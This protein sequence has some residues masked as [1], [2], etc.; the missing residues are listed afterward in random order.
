MLDF[1]DKKTS[2]T[3]DPVITR[4]AKTEPLFPIIVDKVVF[5]RNGFVIVR[6]NF[7]N[8]L[9]SLFPEYRFSVNPYNNKTIKKYSVKG[10]LGYRPEEGETL[11]AGKLSLEK[12]KDM[13]FSDTLNA[14]ILSSEVIVQVS[15][16]GEVLVD[17]E[18]LKIENIAKYITKNIKVK[19]LG[20]VTALK[21]LNAFA[22]QYE[23]ESEAMKAWYELAINSPNEFVKNHLYLQ[24]KY[25]LRS[26]LTAVD[27]ESLAKCISAKTDSLELDLIF[28]EY[29]VPM[30]A[31]KKIFKKYGNAAYEKIRRNPYILAN[32][33][34]IGFKMADDIG[35][36]F[37]VPEYAR[38]RLIASMDAFYRLETQRRG[39]TSL[40]CHDFLKDWLENLKFGEED[41]LLLASIMMRFFS[42]GNYF[43][44][45]PYLDEKNN[46]VLDENGK[47]VY[48]FTSDTD[49]S[50]DSKIIEQMRRI[51]K[52]V[53]PFS[54]Q[55]IQQLK[56]YIERVERLPDGK[57][58]HF[59][60]SQI[61]A[62]YKVL[63]SRISCL[64]GGAG[65]GKTTILKRIIDCAKRMN[66]R[67]K[68][69]SP[70]GKAAKRMSESTGLP[71]TTIHR[72]IGFG[73]QDSVIPE[74]NSIDS[75]KAGNMINTDWLF[76]DESSMIDSRLA[77]ALLECVKNGT[78]VTF[79]GDPNQLPPVSKGCFFY[80][81]I[82]S[83]T[84]PVANLT[85][86]HRQANGNDIND[87]AHAIL[88]GIP[89][90]LAL[91]QRIN[92]K[93]HNYDHLRTTSQ[94]G[95]YT[96]Q[97]VNDKI[98]ND[99]VKRYVD[100]VKAHGLQ[101]VLIITAKRKNTNLSCDILNQVIRKRL[102][103]KAVGLPY[104]HFV[105]GERVMGV[106]NKYFNE[107]GKNDILILN[108]EMGTV[109]SDDK[110]GLYVLIDGESEPRELSGVRTSLELG[111]A[112]TV[113]KSQGS[114]AKYILSTLSISD[115]IM[116]TREWFYTNTTRA[117]KEFHLYGQNMAI[118][119][120]VKNSQSRRNTLLR[121]LLN[122][123]KPH[124]PAMTAKM[125]KE[126]ERLVEFS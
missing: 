113:H 77:L 71:A 52:G 17:P 28:Q 105:K 15:E 19:G 110:R 93:Y 43:H 119:R 67:V 20:E 63:N 86:V 27:F 87:V 61:R 66:M 123:L 115:F 100:L 50:V 48:C 39:D 16:T 40:L 74:G 91:S 41:K 62:V 126:L 54:E 76:V 108:G 7:S 58:L 73:K 112:I 12:S 18:R 109:V 34:R 104:S 79:I 25:N 32:I 26:R 106:E 60:D 55:Q 85:T 96:Q 90:N 13:R 36:K 3:K 23:S 98:Q 81:I 22:T 37:G 99:L 122:G 78:R 117:K 9:H 1:F 120:A 21:L 30:S 11:S 56:P 4:Q 38:Q 80:D 116:L 68:L 35:R 95:D 5:E 31:Q 10:N 47:P 94:G 45:F 111:Y 44:L 59:D 83:G 107:N 82:D 114:E 102:F 64:T 121:H 75:E 24:E 103:P 89:K 84:I 88:S 65:C 124:K 2:V 53:K 118:S 72:L 51:Y 101:D 69:C 46:P 97:Q 14:D 6:V 8:E 29:G 33:D 70:T 92:V 57:E 125:D 49:L 42:N